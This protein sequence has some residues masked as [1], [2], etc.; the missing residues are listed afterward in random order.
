MSKF[1][2]IFFDMDGLLVE[3]EALSF[4]STKETFAAR[5]IEMTKEWFIDEHLGKGISTLELARKK[6]FS[7][8]E[9]QK[10]RTM[11]RQ[12]YVELLEEKAKPVEG[13]LETLE[14]LQGHFLMEVVTGSY[15]N[16]YNILMQRTGFGHFFDFSVTGDDVVKFKPHPEPYLRALDISKKSKA[17]CLV[18]ED[19]GNGTQAAKAA[20]LTC[21]AIPDVLTKT[22]DFSIADKVLQSIRDV[23]VLVL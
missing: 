11:R 15:R 3:T 5:G 6:G 14:L 9:V 8:D 18:L 1:E 10:L 13:A 17:S 19:S 22:H 4:E 21:Y 23:P 20:G 7:E 12:R 16:Q 2:A